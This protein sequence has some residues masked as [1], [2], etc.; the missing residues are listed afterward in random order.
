MADRFTPDPR[1][2]RAERLAGAGGV[3]VVVALVLWLLGAT[4]Q[5]WLLCA[6]ALAGGAAS[7]L[8]TGW[9]ARR[10]AVQWIEVGDEGLTVARADGER[11]IAWT[12]ITRAVRAPYGGG[13]VFTTTGRP[14]HLVLRLDGLP[15]ADAARLAR[16]LRE[17]VPRRGG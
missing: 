14:R 1:T 8:L 15:T 11:T 10:E 4:R 9:R 6:A 7:Y 5:P 16:L 2:A 13:W 12:E 17:R 3:A